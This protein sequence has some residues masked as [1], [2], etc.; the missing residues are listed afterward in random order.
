MKY[1]I[2]FSGG[3]IK[4]AAHIG[5]I[6]VFEEN[7]IKFEYFSGTSS[8]SII[9]CLYALGFS[10]EEMLVFLKNYAKK[11]KYYE[12]KN[13]FKLILNLIFLRKIGIKGF[14]S[15]KYQI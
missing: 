7:N 12:T 6:K 2:C 4:A 14:N 11:I 15:G 3:G 10:S 5:A 9:A 8:G 13:I 1:G